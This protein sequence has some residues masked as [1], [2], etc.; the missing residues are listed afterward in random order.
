MG[1]DDYA[2]IFGTVKASGIRVKVNTVV[3]R[4][5]HPVRERQRQR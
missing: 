3:C 1:E 2:R 5:R 4:V